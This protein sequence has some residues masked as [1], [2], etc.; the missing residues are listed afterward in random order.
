MKDNSYSKVEGILYSVPKLKADIENLKIDLEEVQDIVGIRGASGYEKAGSSTYAF[1]SSVEDEVMVRDEKLGKKIA[2]LTIEIRC[3]QRQLRKVENALGTLT[4]EEL[5]IIEMRY[6]KRYPI[7][8]ICETIDI[9]SDTFIKRR[10]KIIAQRLQ[11]LL[12]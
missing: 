3:K 1:N 12:S 2:A 8:R 4:E 5:A 7:N 10:K 11:Y 9:T 6:F